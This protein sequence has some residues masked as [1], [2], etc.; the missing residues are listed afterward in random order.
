MIGNGIQQELFS[1]RQAVRIPRP[2]PVGAQPVSSPLM[3][4]SGKIDFL[5]EG[6]RF[7][8]FDKKTIEEV[9]GVVEK[10]KNFA[11]SVGDVI[12]AVNTAKS[13]LQFLGV[14]ETPEDLSARLDRF[15][16]E[17][18]RLFQEQEDMRQSQKAIEWRT[19][20][21]TAGSALH[22][23]LLTPSPQ[24]AS[25]L[26]D[27]TLLL[28]QAILT[29]LDSTN[30]IPFHPQRHWRYGR[31]W[32]ALGSPRRPLDNTQEYFVLSN[33]FASA[34]LMN[35]T[36]ESYLS[37]L[38]SSSRLDAPAQERKIWDPSYYVLILIEA[39]RL[40]LAISTAIEPLYRS[41]A[42]YHNILSE[43]SKNLTL[44]ATRWRDNIVIHNPLAGMYW[45]LPNLALFGPQLRLVDYQG[46]PIGAFDPVFGISTESMFRGFDTYCR[47]PAIDIGARGYNDDDPCQGYPCLIANRDQAIAATLLEHGKATDR[48]LRSTGAL[49]LLELASLY[50]KLAN[51]STV[52]QIVD[53]TSASPYWPIS[54]AA[55]LLID[56]KPF[57]HVGSATIRLD[58][59]AKYA[60]NPQKS[61]TGDRYASEL[62]RKFS[63][64]LARRATRSGVQLGF[65]LKIGNKSWKLI[66][67]SKYPPMGTAVDWFPTEL[68][69]ETVEY[70]GDVYDCVQDRHLS[71]KEEAAFEKQGSDWFGSGELGSRVFVNLRRGRLKFRIKIQTE[72]LPGSD[73]GT[74]LGRANVEIVPLPDESS[75]AAI[76]D[77]RVEETILG[78]DSQAW[79]REA[80]RM[81][82]H[83]IPS[84]IVLGKDFFVDYRDAYGRM[85]GAVAEM[86]HQFP[87]KDL[88]NNVPTKVDRD[89]LFNSGIIAQEVAL[90]ERIL[91]LAAQDPEM[92]LELGQ[93]V[94]PR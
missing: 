84:Y 19:V 29:M 22:D 32:N 85:L 46:L 33:G 70:Q 69:E 83:L 5:E 45:D 54:G 26:N 68:I 82:V 4:Q 48:V 50:Q 6:L 13:I 89:P 42:A 74:Y 30:W 75:D 62:R 12:S 38:N 79:V 37:A 52:T 36:P 49:P 90:A 51:P 34:S 72:T 73:Y 53:L 65:E 71:L 87:L 78:S 16:H 60:S 81:T 92:N 80:D 88:W 21:Q 9:L 58:Q 94:I 57:R 3:K 17:I 67:F 20:C 11:S 8:N 39:L 66:E 63:F 43:I 23:Y 35:L 55:P 41:T 40:R 25:D 28:D 7:L 2:S 24:Q 76:L 1:A 61:Y 31:G 64:N 86:R 93:F 15:E 10:T 77:V 27:K 18:T 59:L 91:E 44:F 14:L 47:K 56:P